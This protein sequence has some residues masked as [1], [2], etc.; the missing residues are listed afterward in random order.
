MARK[1]AGFALRSLTAGLVSLALL[2]QVLFA[3]PLAARMVGPAPLCAVAG[4]D[5]EHAPAPAA[6]HN[7]ELCLVCHGGTVPLALL[8][9][10]VAL[11]TLVARR[12]RAESPHAAGQHARTRVW[13]YRSRAPP[14]LA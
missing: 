11:P 6:P 5:T 14:A 9:V 4:G 7:H 1:T 13:N 12:W 8:A 10:A 3:A 2:A